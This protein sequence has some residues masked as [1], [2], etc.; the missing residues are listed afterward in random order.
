[1]FRKLLGAKG[2]HFLVTRFGSEKLRRVAFDDKYRRGVWAFDGDSSG[3]LPEVVKRYLRKG[4][5]LVLGCGRASVLDGL[6]DAELNSVLGVDL[7]GEAIRL[8]GRHASSKVRFEIANMETFT[9]AGRYDEILFSESL[10]YVPARKQLRALFRLASCLKPDGV[11]IVTLA[12]AARY[13]D[14]IVKIR[15]NFRMLEDRAFSDSPRHLLVFQPCDAH[16]E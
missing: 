5:L 1:M 3:E 9:C 11:F 16:A 7:S 6:R 12:E 14:I 15:A 8:A 2:V 10:Y 4:D 13:Q